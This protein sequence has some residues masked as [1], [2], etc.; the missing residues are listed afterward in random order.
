M[1][2]VLLCAMLCGVAGAQDGLSA[3]VAAPATQGGDWAQAVGSA[4][5]DVVV[6]AA[7]AS[8]VGG[9]DSFELTLYFPDP[10]AADKL[11]AALKSAS[12]A[13]TNDLKAQVAETTTEPPPA[14]GVWR[15]AGDTWVALRMTL[16]PVKV[17]ELGK[18]ADQMLKIATDNGATNWTAIGRRAA[19]V[20]VSQDLIQAAIGEAQ[21]T[22]ELTAKA[23][24]YGFG[25]LHA[26]AVR[27]GAPVACYFQMG[28]GYPPGPITA[29]GQAY[30]SVGTRVSVEVWTTWD[31]KRP[32]R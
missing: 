13:V 8:Q 14:T 7:G 10:T 26:V 32:P 22:A 2:A 4:A 18:L 29:A 31:M 9:P 15:H 3:I 12:D 30:F 5:A 19:P 6:T 11:K 21:R 1:I 25:G 24:G 16:A 27:P 20:V 28:K 23:V 17:E